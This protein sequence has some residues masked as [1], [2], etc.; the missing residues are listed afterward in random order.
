MS[1]CINKAIFDD[2]QY[3][4]QSMHVHFES[5]RQR[6]FGLRSSLHQKSSL[7]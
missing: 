4:V 5:K 6:L 7:T 3:S 1:S 2:Q